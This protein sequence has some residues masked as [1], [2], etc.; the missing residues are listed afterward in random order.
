MAGED[1]RITE[2]PSETREPGRRRLFFDCEPEDS[3]R[4]AFLGGRP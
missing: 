4:Q 3:W 1:M 2:G